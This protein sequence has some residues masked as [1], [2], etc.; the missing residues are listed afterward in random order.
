MDDQ[1]QAGF[2]GGF[3]MQ[4]QRGFLNLGALGGVVIVEPSLAQPYELRVLRERH[5]FFDRGHR[6]FGDAHRVRACR[7]EDAAM[8]L[9]DGT[10]GGLVLQLGADRHHP[11]HPGGIGAGDDVV[12]LTVEIGEIEMAMAVC[13]LG[14][15]GQN[16]LLSRRIRRRRL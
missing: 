6:L 11:R 2:L 14:R 12:A 1:R 5:Q 9:G 15:E 3:D 4:A 8:R 7:V 16:R 13:D 10:H